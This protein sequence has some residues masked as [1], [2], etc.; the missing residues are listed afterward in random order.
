MNELNEQIKQAVIVINERNKSRYK[1][2]RSLGIKS[3]E[4]R[5]MRFWSIE[6]I[7]QYAK[8]NQ[9]K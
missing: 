9:L 3:I 5:L 1:Y 7:D 6:K 2:A 8:E 4:A